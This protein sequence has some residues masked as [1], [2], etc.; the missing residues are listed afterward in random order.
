MLGVIN[1][2]KYNVWF[3]LRNKFFTIIMFIMVIVS[4]LVLKH[5]SILENN[6]VKMII[7][8]SVSILLANNL[9]LMKKMFDK[10]SE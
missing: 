1:E 10:K 9:D 2:R 6:E 8:I 3:D 5:F 7:I 4:A